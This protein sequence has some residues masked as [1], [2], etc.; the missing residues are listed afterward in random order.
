MR[1]FDILADRTRSRADSS[2]ARKARRRARPA[3]DGL[4]RREVFTVGFMGPVA[5]V[6]PLS[7]SAATT[8][9]PS[10]TTITQ[11][12]QGTAF[13][14]KW[15]ATWDSRIGQ[16]YLDIQGVQG[17]AKVTIT[18]TKVGVQ[19]NTTQ[20]DPTTG[21]FKPIQVAGPAL[22]MD[23]FVQIRQFR[24]AGDVTLSL[25]SGLYRSLSVQAR[26]S[27]SYVSTP[28]GQIKL[29]Y[30]YDCIANTGKLTVDNIKGSGRIVYSKAH[31]NP[32][33]GDPTPDSPSANPVQSIDFQLQGSDS[34]NGGVNVFV[35]GRADAT[36]TVVVN[37]NNR[38]GYYQ[39][40]RGAW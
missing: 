3:V 37:N 17:D 5:A 21:T 12:Q 26:T 29:T 19:F 16:Y 4:E 30:Q 22:H 28:T 25:G 20:Y 39:I 34:Y 27:V 9:P 32:S 24:D 8:T 14:M 33:P 35:P 23:K 2:E 15:R 1:L 11:D 6:A 7:T 38:P 40:E 13:G 18:R 36:L 10:T 31:L